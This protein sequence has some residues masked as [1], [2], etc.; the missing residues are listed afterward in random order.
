[1]FTYRFRHLKSNKSERDKIQ[2][3]F[4]F[5]IWHEQMIG[6]LS[7]HAWTQ[8]YLTLA[9]KSKDGDYA[10][11]V[12]EHMGFIPVRGSSKKKNAEKGGKEAIET[13]IQQLGS[14]ICG[15]ITV[16]GPKGPRHSCKIGI[17]K[18]AQQSGC[19]IIPGVAVASNYWTLKSWDKFKIPKPFS[20]IDVVYSEP[21]WVKKDAS[22]EELSEVCKMIENILVKL[23][24]NPVQS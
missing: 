22:P 3:A 10:A 4:I 2:G 1:M 13:Y 9:S 11:F 8:P 23:E 15:G 21:I 18:I 5:A 14:G 7:A 17:A 20:R 19:P 12:S 6:F 24:Q 16:D